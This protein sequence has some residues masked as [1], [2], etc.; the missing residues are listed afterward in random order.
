[1]T[2]EFKE[3]SVFDGKYDYLYFLPT[4]GARL[5]EDWRCITKMNHFH[6]LILLHEM[7]NDN[8][9]HKINTEDKRNI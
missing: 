5:K 6:R 8:R 1:M 9:Y 3:M 7:Y 2:C 4:S